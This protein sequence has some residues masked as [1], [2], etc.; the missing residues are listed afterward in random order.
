[1][2]QV[3]GKRNSPGGTGTRKSG[4]KIARIQRGKKGWCLEG[5]PRKKGGGEDPTVGVMGV[6]RKRKTSWGA[7]AGIFWKTYSNT[8]LS[9]FR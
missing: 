1:V 8:A 6:F 7:P 9:V 2:T 4:E 3:E 5:V